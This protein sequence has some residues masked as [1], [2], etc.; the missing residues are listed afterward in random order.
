MP[1]KIRI[2][3]YV[4]LIVKRILLISAATIVAVISTFTWPQQLGWL[5]AM[6]YT[7][8]FPT[9]D[10]VSQDIVIVEINKS[11]IA[12]YGEL[13]WDRSIFA[14][15][16]QN[17]AMG[18][19]TVIGVGIIFDTPR[20]PAGDQL[21]AQVAQDH[22]NIV[23]AGPLSMLYHELAA[24]K[25]NVGIMLSIEDI[26]TNGG[27]EEQVLEYTMDQAG[28]TAISFPVKLFCE[29]N[30][31]PSETCLQQSNR[32]IAKSTFF[33][34]MFANT[35]Y[36]NFVGEKNRFRTIPF[37]QLVEEGT[38]NFDINNKIILIGSVV[39]SFQFVT[40]LMAQSGHMTPAVVI[41]ANA[42]NTLITGELIRTLN[43]FPLVFLVTTLVWWQVAKSGSRQ[44]IL[45]IGLGYG[46]GIILAS[47]LLFFAYRIHIMVMP[48]L[49]SL[50]IT[51]L[52]NIRHWSHCR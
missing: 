39:D 44:R 17:V 34:P 22:R 45:L 30:Q 13:P 49:L 27:I 50:V 40:P 36:I 52:L 10:R 25:P 5:D 28:A 42:L 2:A 16:L 33:I 18:K 29:W 6:I 9:S 32:Y 48:F 35:F 1:K 11:T 14:K 15:A 4:L 37:E 47:V 43:V 41:W 46:I 38:V 8:Y 21:L 12:R 19:N 51:M 7:H 3:I 26:S 24:A 31:W 20:S 23:F